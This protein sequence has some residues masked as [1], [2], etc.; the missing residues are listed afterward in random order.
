MLLSIV[1][2][3]SAQ[4]TSPCLTAQTPAGDDVWQSPLDLRIADIEQAA[5]GGPSEFAR[6]ARS[7]CAHFRIVAWLKASRTL[8]AATDRAS[9]Y[10]V[11]YAADE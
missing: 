9:A 1:D 2:R 5:L 3:P 7:L 4:C 11:Y 6:Y 8:L 10:P